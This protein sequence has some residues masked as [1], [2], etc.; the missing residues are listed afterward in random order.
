[1]SSREE[2]SLS[3]RARE[4]EKRRFP[5]SPAQRRIWFLEQLWPNSSANNLLAA[6]IIPGELDTVLLARSIE[7]VIKRH[8]ILHT[9]FRQE[10][11][12]PIQT[13]EA[14]WEVP[15]RLLT[16]ESGSAAELDRLIYLE[17]HSPFALQRELPLRV[18]LV[19]L[20]QREQVLILNIHHIASDG[21]QSCAIFMRELCALYNSFAEGQPPALGKLEIQYSDFVNWQLEQSS[22]ERLAKRIEDYKRSIEGV[23]VILNPFFSRERPPVQTFEGT[24]LTFD[25][26][27]SLTKRLRELSEEEGV[28]LFTTLLAGFQTLLYRYTGQQSFFVGSP[29]A[30]RCL[31][32]TEKLIG[33]FGNPLAIRADFS[34][35][36]SF[37]EVLR[38]C[39][40]AVAGANLY[41]DIPFDALVSQLQLHRDPSRP[42]IFQ[43]LFDLQPPW[44]PCEINGFPLGPRDIQTGLVPYDMT[45]FLSERKD[46]LAGQLAYNTDL[47][48]AEVVGRVP[49]HFQRLLKD[50][51]EHPELPVSTLKLLTEAERHTILDRWNDTAK[52]L[53]GGVCVHHLFEERAKREP[54][55]IAVDFGSERLSYGELNRRANELAHHLISQG[56]GPETL[57][58]LYLPRSL[59]AIVGLLAILKAG[60]AFVALDTT[61]PVERLGFVLDDSRAS[62]LLTRRDLA[63]RLPEH[64]ASV[65]YLDADAGAIALHSDENPQSSVTTENLSYVIYTSGSTGKP[66]GIAMRHACLSNLIAWHSRHPRLSETRRTLQF[67]AFNFDIAYQEMFTTWVDGGTL[68]LVS[69]EVRRDPERLLAHLAAEEI[70]R[71]YLPFVALENL[72]SAFVGSPVNLSSLKEIITAGEQMRV[73]QRMV[74]FS[75]CL[76]DCAFYN[77]YGPSECHVV[78][79]H[80]LPAAAESWPRLPPI[81]VPL[82]NLQLYLLNE[83]MEPVPVSVQ[84]EIYIGGTGLSRGY[85][86]RPD[87]TAERYVPHPFSGRPGDRLYRTGDLGRYLPDGTIE[88]IGRVDDQAKI[89]GYRVEPGEIAALLNE[90]PDVDDAL[91]MNLPG[92]DGHNRLVAYVVPKQELG[93]NVDD[94]TSQIERWRTVWDEV[95]GESGD[96][97]VPALNLAGWKSSYTGLPI[98]EDEMREWV[99]T[100]VESILSLRPTEVLEI[101]CGTGLLLLRLAPRCTRYVG[102]DISRAGLEHTEQQLKDGGDKYRHVT[103]QPGAA[104]ELEQFAGESFDTVIINSVI[105]QFPSL[106][107]LRNVIEQAVKLV[108]PGGRLFIGD[109]QNLALMKMLHRSVEMY[110]AGT[111][112]SFEEVEKRV[113][114]EMAADERLYIAP[115]FFYALQDEMPHITHVE[116]QLRRGRCHNEMTK[117]RYD[118]TLTIG[119]SP[120]EAAGQERLVDWPSRHLT[121]EDIR[122]LLSRLPD[123]LYLKDVANARLLEE[124]R[125]EKFLQNRGSLPVQKNR[126]EEPGLDPEDLWEA[127]DQAGYACSIF[128]STKYREGAFDAVFMRAGASSS[129]SNKKRVASQSQTYHEGRAKTY[130]NYPLRAQ[131]TRRLIPQLRSYLERK[132]PEYMIP[133][134]FVILEALPLK[135]T[136]KVDREKL[137]LMAPQTERAATYVAP[138]NPVE[139]K[140][141]GIWAGVLGMERIAATDNFF[142]LGGHSLLATQVMWKVRESFGINVPLATLFRLPTVEGFAD[143]LAGVL[144]AAEFDGLVSGSEGMAGRE[145]GEL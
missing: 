7:E 97:A 106:H 74:D 39:A 46:I 105:Q 73:N 65:L 60:G 142:K 68:V 9:T 114:A 28:P 17:S 15:L 127:A 120:V 4:A 57:V 137:A 94:E 31:P 122:E 113:H 93:V 45:L 99:E 115:E 144:W 110:K 51:A 26:D 29:A 48:D 55:L 96:G 132:L 131:V 2:I 71:L 108:K 6:Y 22:H 41:Q 135:P 84:G 107:Y 78:T 88:F 112:V 81:G 85:L 27:E 136:G 21:E 5:L 44:E 23:P 69:E 116:I 130:A 123:S 19:N 43:V 134:L 103:L 3:R 95:Y 129:F 126:D 83:M 63:H 89:R 52:P 14:I 128:W 16:L 86:Y 13:A 12:Q 38:R 82:D 54:E 40:E 133:A 104:T 145:I 77:Q 66:K 119:R 118:A 98:P 34:G 62:V 67:A 143:Y 70:E 90:H 1:M 124:R 79:I 32:G 56:V 139:Q 117:F 50:A 18:C 20:G 87:L 111:T 49:Q 36:L 102:M 100:T 47:F 91:V 25:L 59:D 30:G 35:Q 24:S 75:L 64:E 76:A 61:Y 42:P 109:I 33:Y 11:E 10:G 101:G 121:V 37:R 92:S 138:R 72:A 8:E 140:V 58:G 53:Q 80:E 141:A 125:A